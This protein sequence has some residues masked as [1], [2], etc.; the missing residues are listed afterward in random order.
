MKRI[1]FIDDEKELFPVISKIFSK[2]SYRLVFASDGQEGLL[3]YRN[4]EFDL[5]ISDYRMPKV[6]GFRFYQEIREL[7]ASRKQNT[8]PILFVSAWSDEIKSKKRQ[9]E[10]C[11]FLNKP[12]QV[13]ELMQKASKLLGNQSE[14]E[15]KLESK[16]FLDAGQM[17]FDEG[18]M[19]KEVY[20]VVSGALAAYKKNAQ[21]EDVHV[22][23]IN[24]GELV[25]EMALIDDS[26]RATKLV[27]TEVT[28][29]VPIP[30]D[31]IL[32]LLQSQP[33]WIRLMLENLSKRLRDTLKQIT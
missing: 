6:D 31:K 12:Y 26:P 17:L 9:W 7:E 20:Y 30:A 2:E 29:L 25:G 3:K 21:G 24:A 13:Y 11:E 32:S 8:T 14:A 22:G 23:N 5:V 27:A 10:S 18:E 16:I 15:T 1:L 28:E 4:E 19:S 33:K